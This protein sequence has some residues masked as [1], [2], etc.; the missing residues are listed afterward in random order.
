MDPEAAP[1]TTQQLHAS[2]AKLEIEKGLAPWSWVLIFIIQ[3]Y[4]SYWDAGLGNARQEGR[5]H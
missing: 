5:H 4:L 3:S 2:K 1:G